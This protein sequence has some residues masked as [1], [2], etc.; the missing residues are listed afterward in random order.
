MSDDREVMSAEQAAAFLG[1]ERKTVYE[2]AGRGVIPHRR[3][4][5]RLDEARRG[6]CLLRLRLAF[7][8]PQLRFVLGLACLLG[9]ALEGNGDG[10]GRVRLVLLRRRVLRLLAAIGMALCRLR[11]PEELGERP[12]THAGAP[13]SH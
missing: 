5:K 4:G 11:R 3:L 10:R 13:A 6:A 1:V 12:L 8:P 2:Y 7:G 9:R